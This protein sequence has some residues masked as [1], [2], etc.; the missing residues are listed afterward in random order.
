MVTGAAPRGWG[1][2]CPLPA[3]CL[4][5]FAPSLAG[6][7]V[8]SLGCWGTAW[9]VLVPAPQ[10]RIPDEGRSARS[11][12][13]PC[14]R[15]VLGSGVP[16]S[17]LKARF[18]QEGALPSDGNP[19]KHALL[20][21]RSS[22][23]CGPQR[24]PVCMCVCSLVFSVSLC[25]WGHVLCLCV[26]THVCSHV[27]CVHSR[28]FC[29][30]SHVFRVSALTCVLC[31]HTCSMCLHSHA[32]SMCTHVFCVHSHMFCVCLYS[33]VFC[34][35]AHVCGWLLCGDSRP[36]LL[37]AVSVLVLSSRVTSCFLDCASVRF[38]EDMQQV[39]FCPGCWDRG[40]FA[41]V[42]APGW[43][44]PPPFNVGASLPP[45]S[46]FRRLPMSFPGP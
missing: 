13:Q 5:A 19:R 14:D 18:S 25:A 32:F 46:E 42:L 41:W 4:P 28:V 9:R 36:L 29:V 43:K 39:C 16:P 15:V 11:R 45:S 6:P 30:C 37:F 27:F 3:T 22:Q 12:R 7:A 20:L 8:L 33:H 2:S 26:C 21:R 31:T 34:V 1:C 38:K 23:S 10:A 35:C 17:P 44:G 24:C 40:P